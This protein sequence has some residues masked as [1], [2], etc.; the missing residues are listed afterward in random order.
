M[1]A[2]PAQAKAVVGSGFR[3]PRIEAR[4]KR[5]RERARA[6]RGKVRLRKNPVLAEITRMHL[7]APPRLAVSYRVPASLA[8]ARCF[9]WDGVCSLRGQ[10]SVVL[11]S[12]FIS[13]RGTLNAE[14]LA[15]SNRRLLRLRELI[16][17]QC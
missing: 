14:N 13:V 16:N 1:M 8:V 4:G 3:L 17:V 6:E 15:L 7:E 12:V 10:P 9:E 5:S 11:P 2:A